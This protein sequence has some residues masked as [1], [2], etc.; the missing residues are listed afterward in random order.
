MYLALSRNAS[1]AAAGLSLVAV[2]AVFGGITVAHAGGAQPMKNK[3]CNSS[4]ECQSYT[5]D[6][7]GSAMLLTANAQDA[8]TLYVTAPGKGADGSDISGT[9][10]GVIGRGGSFPLVLTDPSGND[11]M[12]VDVSGDIFYK[13]SLNQFDVTRQGQHVA[14]YTPQATSRTIEDV[15]SGRLVNG[16]AAV[17]LDR[18]FAQSID[19]R[20][21][22]HVFIT[23]NGDT[24]GLFV[25]A[26]TGAGFIVRETQNGHGTLSFDY[27]VI[28][29]PLGHISE[30]M[31]QPIQAPQA[32]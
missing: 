6:G 16:E 15:G 14:A 24:R 4:T 31:G 7:S 18:T 5:N 13:G 26:K 30:R 25:A 23:P 9:Y 27:R 29:S 11:L 10:I 28:A 19:P 1:A 32:K 2:L 12:Y 3:T 20:A 22:Y 8:R 17:A 21:P